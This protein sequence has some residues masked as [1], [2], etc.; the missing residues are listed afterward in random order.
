MY[1]VNKFI[2]R[3]G[4]ALSFLNPISLQ[5]SGLYDPEQ[6]ELSRT[7]AKRLYPCVMSLVVLS[8]GNNTSSGSG[9]ITDIHGQ[10]VLLTNRHVAKPNHDLWIDTALFDGLDALD[11]PLATQ[12]VQNDYRYPEREVSFEQQA[13]VALLIQIFCV[14]NLVNLVSRQRPS[15]TLFKSVVM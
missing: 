15:Q 2:L 9:V 1:N 7:T 5:A 3:V 8:E 14:N 13:D 10:L 4:I 12:L 11:Q 6:G